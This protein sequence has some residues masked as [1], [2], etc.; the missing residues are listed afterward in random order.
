[1]ANE[2]NLKPFT[3][4]DDPRRMNGKPKGT[5]HLSTRIQQMLNDDDFT[6]KM[7][8]S[9]GKSIEFKG[10]PMEAIIRTAMLKA[11]SG[12]KKWAEWLAKYGFGMKQIHE[13]QNSPV[14]EILQKYGLNNAEEQLINEKGKDAVDAGQNTSTT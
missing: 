2:Q 11:M 7:V 14:Q 9:D 10:Q 1:M 4:A 8:G 6:A 13:F 12:D 3:G 5:I